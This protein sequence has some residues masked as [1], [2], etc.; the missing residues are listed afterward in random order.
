LLKLV[1]FGATDF[2]IAQGGV[3]SPNKA[4]FM[5]AHLLAQ[6]PEPPYYAVIFSTIRKEGDHGYH[7]MAEKM[8][9]LAATMPGYL[10]VDS[11]R[12][13]I[14]ITV[15]YWRDLESIKHW[16]QDIEHT[17][18]RNLGREKWYST[19]Q[20]RIAKVEHAYG[21]DAPTGSKES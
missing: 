12:S 21:F 19:Y 4:T 16:R 13:E 3:I 11:A 1:L 5:D 2:A 15:S 7:E 9:K 17:E 8:V 18:A 14:G 20:L 10:G 6:T